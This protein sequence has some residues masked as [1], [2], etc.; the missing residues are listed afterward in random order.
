MC[1]SV[2]ELSSTGCAMPRNWEHIYYKSGGERGNKNL[3]CRMSFDLSRPIFGK[4][5]NN[6]VAK[7]PS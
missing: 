5:S 6:A 2:K 7:L 3:H 4:R 1:I